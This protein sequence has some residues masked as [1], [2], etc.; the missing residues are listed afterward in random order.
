MEV[1]ACVPSAVELSAA[2]S[3]KEQIIA[4]VQQMPDDLTWQDLA[5]HARM[6]AAIDVAEAQI[7]RGEG[8]PHE[9]A[10]RR[11]TEWLQKLSGRQT[12]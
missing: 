6:M 12:A 4:S 7:A 11:I 8:I 3:V 2:M 9:E 1:T 5:E 10:K